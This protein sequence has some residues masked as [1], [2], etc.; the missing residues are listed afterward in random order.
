LS[1]THSTAQ[2]SYA[3]IVIELAKAK[4]YFSSKDVEARSIPRVILTR[5]VREGYIER[6][7][8]GIYQ[9]S[10]QPITHE[11][12]FVIVSHHYR[13]GVMCLATAF[14]I[15]RVLPSDP[16]NIWLALPSGAKPPKF[17]MPGLRIVSFPQALFSEGIELH[18]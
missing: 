17:R 15:H 11:T 18:E 4:R 7:S 5:L 3:E 8:R 10:G 16:L 1:S 2:K 13:Q 14:E 6:L 9:L 12:R